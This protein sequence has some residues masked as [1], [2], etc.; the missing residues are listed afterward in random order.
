M[1]DKVTNVM[2][3]VFPAA[4]SSLPECTV[5]ITDHWGHRCLVFEERDHQIV[6]IHGVQFP[7]VVGV[8][9]RDEVARSKLEA[10]FK[11]FT[12][13]T[14]GICR[15]WPDT[16]F[17][18]QPQSLPQ[19]WEVVKDGAQRSRPVILLH[20]ESVSVAFYVGRASS[21]TIKCASPHTVVDLMNFP[22]ITTIEPSCVY[23]AN[24]Q[25]LNEAVVYSSHGKLSDQDLEK[26]KERFLEALDTQ[27]QA[28]VE[29]SAEVS[30]EEEDANEDVF[31]PKSKL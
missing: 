29:E 6:G 5:A 22:S 17:L 9:S 15:R 1:G 20:S 3:P 21:V 25:T 19:R 2:V 11:K 14:F 8:H 7:S 23:L 28:L 26:F 27:I 16:K 12:R 24:A 4:H 18:N 30:V 31:G 10:F 13:A